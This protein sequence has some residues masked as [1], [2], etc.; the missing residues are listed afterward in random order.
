MEIKQI[1]INEIDIPKIQVYEPL[2]PKLKKVPKL[3][4]DYPAC[5]KVHR[6]NL[7]TEIDIDENGTVIKCGVVMP[8]YEPLNYTPNEFTY[9]QSELS[10]RAEPEPIIQPD[11]TK[12]VKKEKEELYIP[13][14]PLNPQFMKGDYRNDKRLFRFD[15]Y[16][17]IE[18]DG[19]IE[20]VENW[21]EVPFRESF[22]GTPQTLIST[23]LLGVVAG[24]SALL[25]PV[26]KKLI[27]TIFKQLKKKITKEDVK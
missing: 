13:C 14:P 22:I 18:T 17:K 23:S 24:G 2:I 19:V 7:L 8:S 11:L 12:L 10:N 27:S 16:E 4:V 21:K 25:A 3:I 15:S 1:K 5:V 26:I 6:N 20:C 9:T